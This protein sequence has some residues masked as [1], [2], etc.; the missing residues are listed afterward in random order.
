MI[1]ND[2]LET[3]AKLVGLTASGGFLGALL[4]DTVTYYTIS[5]NL[6]RISK[7][8]EDLARNISTI[9]LERLKKSDWITRNII[10]FGLKLAYENFLEKRPDALRK[11]L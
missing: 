6:E 9:G 5:K 1:N 4:G 2:S 8:N 11:Y 3:I 7:V 10:T